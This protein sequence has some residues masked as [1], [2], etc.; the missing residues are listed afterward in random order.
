MNRVYWTEKRDE[1]LINFK[2]TGLSW[3]EI[4]RKFG[5][6]I[7][8][9]KSR[10]KVL[11][12]T[13]SGS[14]NAEDTQDL[15]PDNSFWTPAKLASLFNL[16][17]DGFTFEEIAKSLRCHERQ[18]ADVYN[19]TDW[20]E[21]FDK[22]EKLK[23]K[24]LDDTSTDIFMTD[25]ERYEATIAD[26]KLRL[27]EKTQNQLMNQLLKEKAKTEIIVDAVKEAVYRIP[28]IEPKFDT[29]KK[30]SSN[31]D[32]EEEMG[33]M[34]SDLHIGLKFGLED[35]DG[36]CEY[37]MDIFRKRLARLQNS[38]VSIAQRHMELYPIPC[39]NIFGLGDIVNGMN[40]AG[41]WGPAY[42]ELDVI[43]QMFEGVSEISKVLISWTNI[44]PKIKFFGVFGNHGRGA[45]NGEK[46]VVNWDYVLYK[47]LEAQMQKYD[48]IEFSISTAFQQQ[49]KVKNHLFVLDHGDSQYSAFGLP[50]YGMV[51]A[52]G[53]KIGMLKEIF[54]YMLIGHHHRIA[55]IETNTGFILANGSFVGGDTYSMKKMQSIAIPSQTVFGINNKYGITWKYILN[56]KET[57]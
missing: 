42:M 29:F 26:E 51:R 32:E 54:D 39:L 5:K 2:Q 8:A 22:N 13:Q 37:N 36:V 11:Q 17:K 16:K 30:K 40:T 33:L 57:N 41:A 48:N 14:D 25:A 55:E 38:V 6:T 23:Y 46:D 27:V 43:H 21:F 47:H 45:K 49:A 18:C 19:Q 50:F 7:E 53:R 52:E 12:K 10:Y 56:L 15:E 34:L 28:K 31:P 35:T 20:D 9:C 4:A 24:T 44:F 1:R 3:E